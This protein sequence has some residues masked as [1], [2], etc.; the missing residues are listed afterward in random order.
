MQHFGGKRVG[1]GLPGNSL[2]IRGL[3]VARTKASD[4]TVE[5]SE[6]QSIC[7]GSG[8][9]SRGRSGD[10]DSFELKNGG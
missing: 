2:G 10:A 5:L 8:S 6:S 9:G 7:R 1:G 4:S 3:G